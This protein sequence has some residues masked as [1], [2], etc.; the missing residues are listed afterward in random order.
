MQNTKTK[1]GSDQRTPTV[2]PE[3]EQLLPPLS[4]EQLSE[5]EED[6]L[7][8]GCYSPI[9]V[10]EDMLIVDGHNG[11]HICEKHGLLFRMLV[12]SFTDLLEAKRWA[13]DTQR[14]RRNLSLWELG[15]IALKLK[16][17]LETAAK[18]NQGLRSDLSV[19]SPKHYQAIDTC[20]EMASSVGIGEQAMGRIAQLAEDAPQSLKDAL[21]NK[22]LSVNRAWKILKAVQQYPLEERDVLTSEMLGAVWE[23]DQA[24]E[25]SNRKRQIANIFC[26]AYEK[27]VLL[28]PTLENV[29]C[30]VKCTR[31]RPE[32]IEDS[33]KESYE[34]AQ[35]YQTIQR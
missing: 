18:Q 7:E 11:F 19:N 2:L 22:E 35:V 26:K 9:I 27:S 34:L 3:M 23:M 21:D 30:W 5:L 14:G 32:E 20:K 28:T 33:V 10:N 17:E 13:L 12:F 6:I 1:Y 29:R 4:A 25:E 16:P 24:D 8:N 15:Q 31:M